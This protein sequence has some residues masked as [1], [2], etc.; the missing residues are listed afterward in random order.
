MNTHIH[1]KNL[2]PTGGNAGNVDAIE[3]DALMWANFGIANAVAAM[4]ERNADI[5]VMV[6]LGD[7]ARVVA[8]LLIDRID[9]STE[10]LPEAPE[11][12]AQS[13]VQS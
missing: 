9:H 1:L 6:G 8:A 13:G 10:N 4:A 11:Q 3:T 12:A 2:G 5:D 7:A